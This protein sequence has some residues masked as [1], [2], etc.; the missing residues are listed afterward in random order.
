[1]KEYHLFYAPDIATTGQLPDDEANHAV[2][3]LRMKEGDGLQATD[4]RGNFYDC[5]IT[6]ASPKRCRIHID[7][8]Y[9]GRK[10]WNGSIH[11]AVA[12]TKNMDRME[13]LAEKAT[14]MGLDTLSFVDCKNS[15]RHVVKPE[16]V[17]RIVVSATKQSHKAWKPEVR[18]MEDFRR[19][20]A[21]PFNG[22]KFIAHCYDMDSPHEPA[23]STGTASGAESLP[24]SPY[25]LDV[26]G[27]TGDAL[28]L[29]GP[30]GDFSVEE[31]QAAI[32]A[33]YR[34]ISLGESRLRTETA[35]LAAVHLLNI[36]KRIHRP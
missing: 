18:E 7:H 5:T 27:N 11:L 9:E 29:I 14:E 4:G 17:E 8:Q 19:F 12:P 35:A 31:V 36:A 2:R 3:V 10:L 28:V 24:P 25:L 32:A 23:G 34:P 20:I 26:A 22:Q 15:E 21:H 16:R 30:E 33:G 13:W 1:M 6:M